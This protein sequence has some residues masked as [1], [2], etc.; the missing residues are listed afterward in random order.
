[1]TKNDLNH[2]K[3]KNNLISKAPVGALVTLII[4][5]PFM[6]FQDVL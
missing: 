3:T 4:P 5:K 1:M 6:Y 2:K